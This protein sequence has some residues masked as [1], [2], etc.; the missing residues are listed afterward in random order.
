MSTCQETLG[1]FAADASETAPIA[2]GPF[3]GLTESQ[4]VAEAIAITERQAFGPMS[5][6]KVDTSKALLD[7]IRLA[8]GPSPDEIFGV[9]FFTSDLH[10]ICF[11][12]LFRGSVNTCSVH[13]RP[14]VRRALELNAAMVAL[15][16]VHPS[17]NSQPSDAD[18][19]VT[20]NI[21]EALK[22]FDVTVIEHWIIGKG[23]PYSMAINGELQKVKKCT[24]T[25]KP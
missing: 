4:I 25:K 10:P 11:D 14:I 2:T 7:Y 19:R 16:H 21:V 22:I 15:A 17:G 6:G 13:V 1:L 5:G 9:V 20:K 18:V 3:S 23:E 12:Q 24:R 8:I